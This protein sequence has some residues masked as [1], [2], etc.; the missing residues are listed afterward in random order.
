MVPAI[1]LSLEEISHEKLCRLFH[2]AA[3]ARCAEKLDGIETARSSRPDSGRGPS[4]LHTARNSNNTSFRFCMPK[5]RLLLAD[6]HAVVAQGLEA[7]LKDVF[8]LVEIVHDGRSLL[9][10][11]DTLRPSIGEL[12]LDHDVSGS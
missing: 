10:A 7:L 11:A 2:R 3:F 5:T 6:D 12:C 8:E 4:F 9:N 1:R